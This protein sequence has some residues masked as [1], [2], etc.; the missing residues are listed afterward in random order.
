MGYCLCNLEIGSE[1]FYK[2]HPESEWKEK[3]IRR[4]PFV[5]RE[6][7]RI[8]WICEHSVGHTISV[9][10]NIQKKIVGGHMDA[11]VVVRYLIK[12]ER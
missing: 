10:N 7:G 5:K 11:M 1:E 2:R 12:I 6:D 8:E 3:N 9:P 4:N